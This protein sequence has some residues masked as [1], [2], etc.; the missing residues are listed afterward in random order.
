[1]KYEN[2]S[3]GESGNENKWRNGEK[4][5]SISLAGMALA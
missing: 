3:V 2:I 4:L 5:K 1:M